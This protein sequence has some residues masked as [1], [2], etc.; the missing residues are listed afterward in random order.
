MQTRRQVLEHAL[1]LAGVACIPGARAA[2]TDDTA[3]E[4]VSLAKLGGKP[5]DSKFDNTPALNAALARQIPSLYVPRGSWYFLTKPNP[6]TYPMEIVGGSLSTASLIRRYKP[7]SDLDGL[8]TV[9]SHGCRLSRLSVMAG[10]STAGGAGVALIG[11]TKTDPDYSVLEDLYVSH[12]PG[13]TAT[14]SNAIILDGS[15]R[16]GEPSG[17]R[18]INIRNCHLFSS[19]SAACVIRNGVNTSIRDGGMFP[20]GGTTGRLQITGKGPIGTQTVN[21]DI[22]YLGGLSLDNCQWVTVRAAVITGE[23]TN[24]QSARDVIVSARCLAAVQSFWTR[25]RVID[26]ADLAPRT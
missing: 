16:T 13:T 6:I 12:E 21:V 9:H 5:D 10:G 17:A 25:G 22:S 2:T 15:A 14:W 19:T 11:D 23:V 4:T 3:S 7:G 8:L 24:A 1:S 18:D 26:P 20:A